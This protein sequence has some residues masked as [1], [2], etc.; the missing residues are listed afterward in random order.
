MVETRSGAVLEASPS[1]IQGSA[2]T[3]QQQIDENAEAIASATAKMEAKFEALLALIEER[4]PP[5]PQETTP[6]RPR[7]QIIGG[8]QVSGD[9][10]DD[11]EVQAIPIRVEARFAMPGR[12]PQMGIQPQPVLPRMGMPMGEEFE[13]RARRQATGANL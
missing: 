9:Q 6:N 11:Q 12:P 1:R 5:T 13:P 7:E 8:D 4:L 3:I 2:R 10:G